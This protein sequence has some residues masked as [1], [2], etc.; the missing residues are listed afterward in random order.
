MSSQ[1][2]STELIPDVLLRRVLLLAGLVATC[3][4]CIMLLLLPVA[5]PWR[6]LAAIAW[7]GINMRDLSVIRAGHRRC[8]RFRLQH[9]GDV[10]IRSHDGCWFPA[11]LV[12]GSVVLPSVAWLRFESENGQRFAE[13]LWRKRA[14]S[15]AWRRLQVIW[16]HLG[17]GG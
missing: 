14:Q 15:E 9:D 12:R 11:T 1:S 6:G 7:L 17:A 13:L 3:V 8:D 10:E 16:R 4:G 5:W 2:Y